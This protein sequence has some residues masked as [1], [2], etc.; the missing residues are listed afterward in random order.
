MSQEG[1]RTGPKQDDEE[2]E[3][4]ICRSLDDVLQKADKEGFL[5]RVKDIA[6]EEGWRKPETPEEYLMWFDVLVERAIKE[7][8]CYPDVWTMNLYETH[9]MAGYA[10]ELRCFGIRPA[11]RYWECGTLYVA[12]EIMEGIQIVS[13]LVKEYGWAAV[14]QNEKSSDVFMGHIYPNQFLQ[15][16]I[17]AFDD[18]ELLSSN[19]IDRIGHCREVLLLRNLTE[20]FAYL[21]LCFTKKIP[22]QQINY[23][24]ILKNMWLRAN[25][26]SSK[27]KTIVKFAIALWHYRVEEI[28]QGKL[29]ELDAE[30]AIILPPEEPTFDNQIEE[31]FWKAWKEQSGIRLF[32]QYEIGRHHVNFAHPPTKVAIEL[33]GLATHQTT[34]QIASERRRQREIEA[35]GW[36]VIR[37]ASKEIY[38]DVQ[39]CVREIENIIQAL[40]DKA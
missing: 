33:D 12:P 28:K 15:K 16:T 34:E 13:G 31:M 11:A 23:L 21:A 14:K 25:N 8:L 20:Q 22:D 24:S 39:Q 35:L 19:E 40:Q 27:P 5:K 32:H 2:F 3:Q 4:W 29:P 17:A 26:L 6:E 30:C 7:A 38:H 9:Q 37:F 36:K 10:A 1:T 18:I